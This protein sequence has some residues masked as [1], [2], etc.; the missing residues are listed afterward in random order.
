M[1]HGMDGFTPL[2]TILLVSDETRVSFFA[3]LGWF[4]GWFPG[5]F[6]KSSRT[7]NFCQTNQ[8]YDSLNP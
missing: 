7:K 3:D 5:W 6:D 4:P 2:S 1:L 8:A